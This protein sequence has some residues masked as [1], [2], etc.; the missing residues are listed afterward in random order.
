MQTTK[1]YG[2]R[3]PEADDFIDSEDWA[4]MMDQVDAQL[5]TQEEATGKVTGDLESLAAEAVKGK[6]NL[7]QGYAATLPKTAWTG[8]AAPYSNTV[9]IQGV[10]IDSDVCVFADPA[11]TPSQAEAWAGAMILAGEA[12]EGALTLKA[13]GDKPGVD[14]PVRVLVGDTVKKGGEADAG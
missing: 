6:A 11:W 3:K 1:Y 7:Y 12:A 14:L 13:Y 2:F 10:G 4:D 9:E 5:K 8:S